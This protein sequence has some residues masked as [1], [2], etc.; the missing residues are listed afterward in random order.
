MISIEV[1][2]AFPFYPIELNISLFTKEI[3]RLLAIA[4]VVH[5][6]YDMMPVENN[7]LPMVTEPPSTSSEYK[8]TQYTCT[9]YLHR[10]LSSKSW[11]A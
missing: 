8:Q 7:N 9:C 1:A 4:E 5:A 10:P 3:I 2:A 6:A 11:Q